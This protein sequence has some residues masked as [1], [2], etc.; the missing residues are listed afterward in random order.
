MGRLQNVA[1]L[2]GRPEDVGQVGGSGQ[3]LHSTAVTTT[4]P[5]GSRSALLQIEHEDLAVCCT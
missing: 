1:V 3:S 2:A 5:G 4:G